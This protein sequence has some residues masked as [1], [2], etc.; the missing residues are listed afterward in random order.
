MLDQILKKLGLKSINDL[1][2][3]ERETWRLDMAEHVCV[4][5]WLQGHTLHH[6]TA[7]IVAGWVSHLGNVAHRPGMRQPRAWRKFY[8]S[9][10]RQLRLLAQRGDSA[11]F[12]F[13]QAVTRHRVE[14]EFPP[15]ISLFP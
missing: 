7:V 9:G 8:C 12:E 2:P 14:Y 10:L 4:E 11:Y 3:A 5:K 15:V 6:K 1:T 13:A